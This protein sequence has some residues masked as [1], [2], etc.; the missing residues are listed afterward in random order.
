MS[1]ERRGIRVVR[2]HQISYPTET[3]AK[4][5]IYESGGE[6]SLH[7]KYFEAVVKALKTST[8]REGVLLFPRDCRLL[9]RFSHESPT[10]E[11]VVKDFKIKRVKDISLKEIQ[12]DGFDNKN[13]LL[14]ELRSYY[15][16]IT[17]DS[18]ITVINFKIPPS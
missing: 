10:L 12:A 8:I 16:T 18:I 5:L 4:V 7:G 13:A 3:F 2:S 6:L 11:V 17:E 15:P 9:L 1:A 14:A